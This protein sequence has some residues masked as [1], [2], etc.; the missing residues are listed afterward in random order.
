LLLSAKLNRDPLTLSFAAHPYGK[1]YLP[2]ANLH[3]NLSHTADLALCVLADR[4]VGID[5]EHLRPIPDWRD[6]AAMLFSPSEQQAL[7]DA[8]DAQRDATFLS[9]WTRKEALVKAT[10]IGLTDDLSTFSVPS[11]PVSEPTHLSILTLPNAPHQYSLTAF[12][13]ADGY[14]AAVA[15]QTNDATLPTIHHFKGCGL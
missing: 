2:D 3:F 12:Q 11:Q 7:A 8:P 15:I 6:L 14:L 13:P 9:L 1:P 5:V 10:G 4:P